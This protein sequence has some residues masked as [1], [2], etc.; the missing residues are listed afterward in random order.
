MGQKTNPIGNRLGIIRGWDSNWYGG[1]D[2]GDKIAEDAKI[3]KYIH[4]RLSK[5]SVSNWTKL[6]YGFKNRGNWTTATEYITDDVVVWGGS[7]YI[8]LTPHASTV[9]END[10][11][12]NKW[13]KFNGGIRWRNGWTASTHYLKDDIVRDAVGSVYIATT[14]HDSTTEFTTDRLAGKWTLFVAGGADVLPPIQVG[15]AGQSLTVLP[16]GS[17]LS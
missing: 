15:D 17:A 7:S 9:F 12:A 4:A 10:L 8:A 13:Q 3:R 6:T 1:N 14:E 16:D 2:Y 5:A 11:S